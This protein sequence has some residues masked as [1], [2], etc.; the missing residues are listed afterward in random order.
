LSLFTQCAHFTFHFLVFCFL[1][2][3]TLCLSLFETLTLTLSL[4]SVGAVLLP[5]Q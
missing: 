4:T 5:A 3:H 1:R 2:T